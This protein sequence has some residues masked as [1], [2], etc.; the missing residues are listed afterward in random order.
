MK[1]D[2]RMCQ[3]AELLLSM[4]VYSQHLTTMTIIKKASE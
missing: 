3:H 1:G 2:P 4:M